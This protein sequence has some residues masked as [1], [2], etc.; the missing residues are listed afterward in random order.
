MLKSCITYVHMNHSNLQYIILLLM[1]L[2]VIHLVNTV[3]VWPTT[4][5]TVHLVTQ[6]LSAQKQVGA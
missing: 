1:Q 4:P 5:A 2:F 6:V 3:C